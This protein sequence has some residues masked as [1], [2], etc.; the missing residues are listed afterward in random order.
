MLRAAAVAVNQANKKSKD[1]KCPK[2][3]YLYYKWEKFNLNRNT[4]DIFGR[5]K[6]KAE[7]KAT[8]K[9][10]QATRDKA[11]TQVTSVNSRHCR[12]K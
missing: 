2:N 1:D 11:N 8:E 12:L 9:F 5:E 7:K 6:R 3:P 4:T 10:H